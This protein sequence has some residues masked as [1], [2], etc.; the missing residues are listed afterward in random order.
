MHLRRSGELGNTGDPTTRSRDGRADIRSASTIPKLP[1]PPRIA[2][3]DPHAR[4]NSPRRDAHPPG[5]PHCQHFVAN[6]AITRHQQVLASSERQAA[7][8]DVRASAGRRDEPVG[9]KAVI[10]SETIAPPSTRAHSEDGSMATRSGRA[11][12]A[13]GR[14][15]RRRDRPDCVRRFAPRSRAGASRELET[16]TDIVDGGQPT[17]AAGRRSIARFQTCLASS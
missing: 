14:H 12:R 3:R 5:T 13:R 9:P 11:G 16:A 15:R 7:E 6:R 10:G 8:A 1:P 4:A 2:R 17:M